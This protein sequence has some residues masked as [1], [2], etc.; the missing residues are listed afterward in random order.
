MITD[1]LMERG[2]IENELDEDEDEEYY[3]EGEAADPFP[4]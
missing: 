1:E 4:N 3:E 2:I